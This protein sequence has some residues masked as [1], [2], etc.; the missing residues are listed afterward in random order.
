[1]LQAYRKDPNKWQFKN[2]LP[3]WL[4]HYIFFAWKNLLVFAEQRL[5][6]FDESIIINRSKP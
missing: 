5:N 4:T 6:D 3:H 1:M 2:F